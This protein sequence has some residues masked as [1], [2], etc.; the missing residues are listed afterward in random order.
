MKSFQPILRHQNLFKLRVKLPTTIAEFDSLVARV[1]K[2]YNLK[3]AHHAAAIIS[4]AIRHLDNQTAY[5][6]LDYLGQSV[7]KNIA[8][9][10]A[11]H[12]SQVLRHTAQIDHLVSLLRTEPS[13]TQAR[14]ELQ[15]AANDGSDVAKKALENIDIPENPFLVN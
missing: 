15:K 3:D 4:V 2:K 14:D 5:T 13:N 12:K 1:V 11:D 7:L 6:T 9:H 8:N 10:V